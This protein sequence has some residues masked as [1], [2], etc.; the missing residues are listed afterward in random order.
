MYIES[1]K[2]TFSIR[3]KNLLSLGSDATPLLNTLVD[4]LYYIS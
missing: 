3:K 4:P 1:L 2:K